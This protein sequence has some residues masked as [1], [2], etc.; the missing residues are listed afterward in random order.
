MDLSLPSLAGLA[1]GAGYLPGQDR[2]RLDERLFWTWKVR[3]GQPGRPVISREARDLIRKM[4]RD[5][6]TWGAH[7]IHG[8]LLKLGINIAESSGK[9]M[10]RRKKPMVVDGCGWKCLRMHGVPTLFSTAKTRRISDH[11]YKARHTVD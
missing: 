1:L 10:I 3:H 9:Y 11:S 2:F 8:E 7:R 4:C 5:N 6:P